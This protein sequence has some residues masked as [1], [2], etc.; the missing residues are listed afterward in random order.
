MDIHK[1]ASLLSRD[2]TI[3]AKRHYDLARD[4][5]AIA[6]TWRQVLDD[7]P[8]DMLKSDQGEDGVL[9]APAVS[10]GSWAFHGDSGEVYNGL[11]G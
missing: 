6:A 11:E 5:S 10:Q 8:A 1:L 7:R 3:M 2:Y 4:C 9:G